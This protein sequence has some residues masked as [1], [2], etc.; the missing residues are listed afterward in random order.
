M[1]GLDASG[2]SLFDAELPERAAYVVGN[3]SAGISQAV[4]ESCT[5]MLSI[6]LANDVE[7]LNAAVAGALVCYEVARR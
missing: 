6:P 1:V 3:E 7:S 2:E 5:S 4:R